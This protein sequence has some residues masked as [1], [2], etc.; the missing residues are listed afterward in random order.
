MNASQMQ[1]Q[2]VWKLYREALAWARRHPWV[3]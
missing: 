2:R 3:T 1:E